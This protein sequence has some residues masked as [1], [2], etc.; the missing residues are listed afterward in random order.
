[1]EN[2][3]SNY[4]LTRDRVEGEFLKYDQYKMI[5]KFHLDHDA[6]YIFLRFL[7]CD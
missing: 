2:R 7:S 4:D 5:E 1:M 6:D 3:K